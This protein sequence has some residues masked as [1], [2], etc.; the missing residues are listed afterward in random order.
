M[1]S[2]T[3]VVRQS[4]G[5]DALPRVR[6]FSPNRPNLGLPLALIAGTLIPL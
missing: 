4:A 3:T 1:K 2:L 5:R 6:N